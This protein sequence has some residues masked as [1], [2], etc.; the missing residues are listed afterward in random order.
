MQEL[1]TPHCSVCFRDLHS[2]LSPV[3]LACGHL[4]CSEC[5]QTDPHA[6]PI[7]S[8]SSDTAVPY[9]PGSVETE[10][11]P[12]EVMGKVYAG[13]NTKGV[14]CKFV[15][16]GIQC[17]D[18]VR[19]RYLHG[20]A[21]LGGC[22]KECRMCRLRFSSAVRCPFCNGSLLDSSGPSLRDF[23]PSQAESLTTSLDLMQSMSPIF[24][25]DPLSNRQSLKDFNILQSY[26]DLTLSDNSDQE[27]IIEVQPK[28]KISLFR[29][30]IALWRFF[31]TSATAI[32]ARLSRRQDTTMVFYD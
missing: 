26:V 13:V 1:Y 18:L 31:S 32:V 28:A 16:R 29:L 21:C 12:D 23:H 15:Y 14:L 6:C 5:I 17:P 25:S 4:A 7:D 20:L 3:Q 30:I 24:P 22:M 2:D 8:T 10:G 27:E 11:D 19:C 9:H